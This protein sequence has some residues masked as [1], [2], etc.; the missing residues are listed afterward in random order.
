MDAMERQVNGVDQTTTI[1]NV[2]FLEAIPVRF[3]FPGGTLIYEA[4][5]RDPIH[6]EC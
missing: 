2:T 3:P 6:E 4:S 5:L 1:S